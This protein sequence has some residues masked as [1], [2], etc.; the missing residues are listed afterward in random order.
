MAMSYTLCFDP[1]IDLGLFKPCP[2]G[3]GKTL[4]ALLL[5]RNCG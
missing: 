1:H 2:A 3:S 5:P 4:L